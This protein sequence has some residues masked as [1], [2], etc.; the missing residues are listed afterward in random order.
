MSDALLDHLATGTTT[1]C[2]AWALSPRG[3]GT[4]GFTDHDEDLTFEGI[5][6]RSDWGF[7][8]SALEQSTGL[9]VDNSEVVGILSDPSIAEADVVAGRFDG[10]GVRVWQVNWAAPDER[11]LI[12]RGSLGQ[13]ERTGRLFRAELRGLADRLQTPVGRAYQKP[14]SAV[15]GDARCRVDL[16][17]PAHFAEAGSIA[18]DGGVAITL[19]ELP[20]ADGWFQRGRLIVLEG[21]AEGIVGTVKRDRMVAGQRQIELWETLSAGFAPGDRVRLE[22]GCDKRLQ[23]CRDRFDNILNFRGFPDIP[24]E[25]WLVSYPVKAGMNDGGSLRR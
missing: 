15:L 18:V 24:G 10:A 19:P 16:D 8:A 12:F 2:R 4:I 3:R 9:S 14:C 17:D 1:V 20:H 6:F 23:T 5:E 11:R 21:A 7:A 25:D 22:V 13:I